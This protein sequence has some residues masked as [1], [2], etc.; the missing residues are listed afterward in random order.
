VGAHQRAAD[1]I[2][3]TLSK[4][5]TY[6]PTEDNLFNWKCSIKGA[7]RYSPFCSSDS[8]IRAVRQPVQRWHVL[9]QAC[10]SGR[11]S[12]QTTY[13]MTWLYHGTMTYIADPPQVTFITKIYHPGINEEGGICVPILR[14]QVSCYLLLVR[15]RGWIGDL[16]WKPSITLATGEGYGTAADGWV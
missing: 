11:F 3:H 1:N 9:L 14:D 13:G 15:A 8:E 6:E 7:V 12:V 5:I 16:Q 4:G 2:E 10:A